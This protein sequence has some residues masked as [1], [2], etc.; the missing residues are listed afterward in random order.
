[1]KTLI[2]LLV[3]V[4]VIVLVKRAMAGPAISPAESSERVA[5]GK[6][7]LID[8]REPDEWAGGVAE[9]ALLLSLSDL[10]GDRVKWKSALEQNRGKELIV[11]CRSGARSGIAAGI[12]RKEGFTVLNAGGF[13]DWVSAG[14][15]VR[16]P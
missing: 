2:I 16:K 11:Y 10:R 1:M 5:A 9:P 8:V 12:L 13:G 6:A 3:V 15:P 7:V 4:A 14:L